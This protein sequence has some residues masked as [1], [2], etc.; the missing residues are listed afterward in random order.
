MGDV[1]KPEGT[2]LPPKNLGDRS[3]GMWGRVPTVSGGTPPPSKKKKFWR[4]H[5]GGM[6]QKIPGRGEVP[7]KWGRGCTSNFFF[8][9]GGGEGVN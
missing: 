6:S 7:K 4:D 3:G 9:G 2:A 8:F 1:K 5:S